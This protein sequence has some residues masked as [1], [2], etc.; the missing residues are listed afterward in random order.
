MGESAN[1]EPPDERHWWE[2]QLGLSLG[3]GTKHSPEPDEQ[4]AHRS[5]RLTRSTD[6]HG[7]WEMQLGK[8]LRRTLREDLQD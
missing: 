1:P 7:W 5:F 2:M 6:E 4:P 8:R 3:D